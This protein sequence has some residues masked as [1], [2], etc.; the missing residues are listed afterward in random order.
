MR[1]FVMSVFTR[2]TSLYSWAVC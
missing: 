2:I 1:H